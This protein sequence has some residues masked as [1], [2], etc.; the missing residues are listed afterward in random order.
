MLDYRPCNVANAA[1]LDNQI[2]DIFALDM[3]GR[4]DEICGTLHVYYSDEAVKQASLLSNLRAHGVNVE[5][6][7]V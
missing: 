1:E 4:G 2:R 5:W 7:K 6:H 3:V